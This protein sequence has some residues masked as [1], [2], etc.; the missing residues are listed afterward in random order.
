MMK[1]GEIIAGLFFMAVGLG[2][3][4]GAVKLEIGTLTEPQPGFFPFWDGVILILLSLIFIVQVLKGRSSGGTAFGRLMGPAVLL[5]TLIL[6]VAVLDYI[7]Y[8]VATTLL[9]VVVL[10]ILETPTPNSVLTSLI[11]AVG[12]YLIF[13]RLLGV[14]LPAG[15][16][17]ALFL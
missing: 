17:A 16:V 1:R 13:V 7:G 4:F 6:Y 2:F 15:V 9:S 11:L 8:I 14:P 3:A 10:K 5:V 12:S